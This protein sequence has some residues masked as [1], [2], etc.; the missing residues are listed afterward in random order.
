MIPMVRAYDFLS[1]NHFEDIEAA[2]SWITFV[3]RGKK[4]K[5]KIKIYSGNKIIHLYIYIY[6]DYN[7]KQ[8]S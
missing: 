1:F 5:I 6:I 7:I 3:R 8:F 2:K 4:I